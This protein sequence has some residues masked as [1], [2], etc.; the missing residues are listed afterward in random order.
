MQASNN[1]DWKI[2]PE[3]IVPIER[4]YEENPTP[5]SDGIDLTWRNEG[6]DDLCALKSQQVA[7]ISETIKTQ[8]DLDMFP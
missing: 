4:S 8:I 5:Y 3:R 6:R 2:L 1:Q 7:F